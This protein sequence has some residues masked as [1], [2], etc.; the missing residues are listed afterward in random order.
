MRTLFFMLGII[1]AAISFTG[2]QTARN[3]NIGQ[4]RGGAVSTQ[5][6]AWIRAG[7]PIEFEGDLWYPVDGIESL[8]D[9]EVF[10]VT[11]YKGIEVF[12]D[13]VDVRPYN[14]L[15]TKF[16]KNKFRYFKRHSQ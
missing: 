5:E 8:T 13:R 15:Y 2:C 4:M 3:G 9:S 16:D 14:R 11:E 6:A 12:V 1:T 10:S 7:E